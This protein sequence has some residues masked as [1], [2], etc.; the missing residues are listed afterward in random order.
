M[1]SGFEISQIA[2]TLHCDVHDEITQNSISNQAS[3]VLR[4]SHHMSIAPVT[5]EPMGFCELLHKRASGKV[6]RQVGDFD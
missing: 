4:L 1:I 5:Q 6:L 2:A 3:T